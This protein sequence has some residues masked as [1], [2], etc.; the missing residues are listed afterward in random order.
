LSGGRLSSTWLAGAFKTGLGGT[1]AAG[2]GGGT[3]IGPLSSDGT[4]GTGVLAGP[5][6]GASTTLTARESSACPEEGAS[7]RTA[8]I[9]TMSTEPR[10]RNLIGRSMANLMVP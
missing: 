1:W 9:P 10:K 5:G 7:T 3:S 2:A 4:A 6:I 8:N